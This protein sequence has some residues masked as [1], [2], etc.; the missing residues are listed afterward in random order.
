MDTPDL[1]EYEAVQALA[2]LVEADLMEKLLTEANIP[3]FIREW[4]DVNDDGIWVEQNGWGWVL[5]RKV[6]EERIR[7]MYRE[8]IAGN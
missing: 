8:R 4:H 3:F 7:T 2:N 6:D 5:G 1:E